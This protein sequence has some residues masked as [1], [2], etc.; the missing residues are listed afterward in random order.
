MAALPL[1]LYAVPMQASL[2]A[3]LKGTG[4]IKIM[5]IIGAGIA[6]TGLYFGGISAV[7]N[8]GQENTEPSQVPQIQLE[9]ENPVQ[10]EQSIPE[11]TDGAE[12]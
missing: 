12:S 5:G 1:L 2:L 9:L 10:N 7:L 3:K 4:M 11:K 8:L 6:G